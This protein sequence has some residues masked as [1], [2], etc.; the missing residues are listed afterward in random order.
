MDVTALGMIETVGLVSAI[1]AA[2]AGLKAADVRL[3][4]ADYVRGGLVMVRFEG[5]VAAVRSAVDAG[6]AAA[7]RVGKVFG[8]HVIARAAPE[9]FCML[10]SDVGQGPARRAQDGCVQCGG[11]EGGRRGAGLVDRGAGKRG[12]DDQPD[13]PEHNGYTM[14]ADN[15]VERGDGLMEHNAS[16]H[17]GRLEKREDPPERGSHR[18]R[19]TRSGPS[20][21]STARRT[22][23]P[24]APRDATGGLRPPLPPQE[25]LE[26]WKVLALRSFVRTLP[27]FPLSPAE[28]RYA[29][30]RALMDALATYRAGEV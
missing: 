5:D 7:S 4:G 26:G 3:L 16:E 25:E 1:E 19:R 15:A 18:G 8:A 9:V 10:A 22:S 2:D 21:A 29:T 13:A 14:E 23:S 20:T 11:C 6:S 17:G 30:K 28:I 27:G 12:V 24:N